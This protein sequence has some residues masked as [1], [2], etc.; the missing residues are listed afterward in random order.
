MKTRIEY[1]PNQTSLAQVVIP[2]TLFKGKLISF[3][4]SFGQ[5]ASQTSTT[6]TNLMQGVY[7]PLAMNSVVADPDTLKGFE[8]D[9]FGL[10]NISGKTKIMFCMASADTSTGNNRTTGLRLAKDGVG[11]PLTVCTATT[12][13]QNFAKLMSHYLIE[14]EDGQVVSAQI[15]NISGSQ[16]VT[17]LRAK[18]VIHSVN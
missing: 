16:N 8:Q 3:V 18:L 7:V 1:N 11:I 5:V 2:T 9:G 4:S 6:F 13:T 17:A 12:G 10:K 15:A 14:V